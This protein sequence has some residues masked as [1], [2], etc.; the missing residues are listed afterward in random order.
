MIAEYCCLI[1]EPG[2]ERFEAQLPATNV[3]LSKPVPPLLVKTR[4][5]IIFV[6]LA[7]PKS[8]TDRS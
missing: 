4:K 3:E 6:Y 8:G 2:R 1:C 7:Q 5:P